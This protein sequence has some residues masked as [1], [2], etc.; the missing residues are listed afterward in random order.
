MSFTER[1]L[2][3]D[4]ILPARR[5]RLSWTVWFRRTP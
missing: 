3:G 2:R 4:D 1:T 5:E